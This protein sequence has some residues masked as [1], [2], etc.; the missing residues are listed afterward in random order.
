M[1]RRPTLLFD[2][3]QQPAIKLT[4]SKSDGSALR[5]C[6]F[7]SSNTR[8]ATPAGWRDRHRPGADQ[9]S[10]CRAR[11]SHG[12]ALEQLGVIVSVGNNPADRREVIRIKSNL[13]RSS[14]P[15]GRNPSCILCCLE[16][17]TLTP[18]YLPANRHRSHES[19]RG[20]LHLDKATIVI[21]QPRI[22]VGISLGA[23]PRRAYTSRK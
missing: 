13:F 3:Q 15:D 16:Q 14:A 4:S 5:E 11:R 23:A 7:I 12:E 8:T 17:P 10:P 22:A 2:P 18:S 19:I 9:A 1:T 6:L 20:H 21:G